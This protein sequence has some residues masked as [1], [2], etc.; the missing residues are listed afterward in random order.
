MVKLPQQTELNK[1]PITHGYHASQINTVTA[2]EPQK[3]DQS[4][5]A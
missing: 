5:R 3:D 2:F 4:A 1:E